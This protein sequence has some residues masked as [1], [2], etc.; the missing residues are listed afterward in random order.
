MDEITPFLDLEV[1][2]Q[3]NECCNIKEAETKDE[4]ASFFRPEATVS[5]IELTCLTVGT[6]DLESVRSFGRRLLLRTLITRR[7]VGRRH[8]MDTH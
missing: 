7:L 3:T 5:P 6:N 4:A 2:T 8:R 1:R